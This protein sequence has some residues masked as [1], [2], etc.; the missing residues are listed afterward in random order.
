MDALFLLLN[1][2][3]PNL[4]AAVSKVLIE[5]EQ[6]FFFINQ[7]LQNIDIDHSTSLSLCKILEI[8]LYQSKV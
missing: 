3:V 2:R 4:A 5:R 6:M 7:F 8:Y 1:E